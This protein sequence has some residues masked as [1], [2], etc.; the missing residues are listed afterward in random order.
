MSSL[1]TEAA[2]SAAAG[3]AST[4]LGHPLDCVKVRLQTAKLSD[5]RLTT[6]GCAR[7]ML[8]REGV[9][10]F[11]RGVG[12]PLANAMLL[13]TVMFVCFAEAR[14]HLPQTTVGSL[15]AGGFSG[16]VQAFL[17]TPLDWLKIQA[18]L[19]STRQ[20]STALLLHTLRHHPSQLYVGHTMN[21]MREACFTACYLGLYARLRQVLV[22][23]RVRM[24]VRLMR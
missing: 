4:I 7:Q 19:S 13:N 24:G 5:G 15:L 1:T 11:A 14:R 16:A 6:L 10:A 18:Q 21:L 2:A 20:S 3:V 23:V 17:T 22:R 9:T 12:P 8:H